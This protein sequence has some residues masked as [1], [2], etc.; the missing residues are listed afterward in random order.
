[1]SVRLG[2]VLSLQKQMQ[3]ANLVQDNG[4]V[5]NAWLLYLIQLFNRVVFL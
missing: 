1:M 2:A 5:D 3:V 4:G